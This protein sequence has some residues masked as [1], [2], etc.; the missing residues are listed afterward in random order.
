[1]TCQPMSSILLEDMLCL[2]DEPT[3][4]APVSEE[5]LESCWAAILTAFQRCLASPSIV[6][7]DTQLTEAYEAACLVESSWRFQTCVTDLPAHPQDQSWLKIT[8]LL[9]HHLH[10]VMQTIGKCDGEARLTAVL[11]HWRPYRKSQDAMR[12]VF[13]KLGCTDIGR[14]ARLFLDLWAK[15][16]IDD[17]CTLCLIHLVEESRSRDSLNVPLINGTVAMLRELGLYEQ[18]FEQP[19]LTSVGLY[20]AEEAS[21]NIDKLTLVPYARHVQRLMDDEKQRWSKL[22][23]RHDRYREKIENLARVE[24]VSNH[25]STLEPSLVTALR[26]LL[27]RPHLN[28]D[29][30]RVYGIFRNVDWGLQLML[31]T[32][33]VHVKAAITKSVANGSGDGVENSDRVLQSLWSRYAKMIVTRFCENAQ[34]W[35][36]LFTEFRAA[37]AAD[38][39][40][41]RRVK[42][43]AKFIKKILRTYPSLQEDHWGRC[44]P[45]DLIRRI[46]EQ[47]NRP[48]K[49][50]RSPWSPVQLDSPTLRVTA[51]MVNTDWCRA[52]SAK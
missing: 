12:D 2:L 26:D 48:F 46:A 22:G 42:G 1:M 52:M 51:R 27:D 30:F 18:I 14:T 31:E 45:D 43:G 21:R 50:E 8:A 35:R 10:A 20:F 39:V 17:N 33:G 38:E 32:F 11:E 29:F 40:R 24:M 49:R 16:V 7:L 5:L 25:R 28:E 6:G 19:V 15:W 44:L 34:L 13:Y 47:A 23:T 4:P 3:G 36:A 9:E 37:V 41:D